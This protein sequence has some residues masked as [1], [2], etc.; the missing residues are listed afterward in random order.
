MPSPRRVKC[1][2]STRFNL[3]ITTTSSINNM[4]VADYKKYL[5]EAVLNDRRTVVHTPLFQET[6]THSHRSHID[7]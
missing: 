7:C 5:A 3:P 2:S 6:N 1:F 4:A